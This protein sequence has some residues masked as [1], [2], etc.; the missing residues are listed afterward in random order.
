MPRKYLNDRSLSVPMLHRKLR[1][2]RDAHDVGRSPNFQKVDDDDVNLCCIY[3]HDVLLF[4]EPLHCPPTWTSFPELQTCMRLYS[5]PKAWTD[6]SLICK[7]AGGDLVKIINT[8]EE[9]YVNSECHSCLSG[10]LCLSHCSLTFFF[11]FSSS[12]SSAVVIAAAAAF[13]YLP[14]E[15]RPSTNS[16]QVLSFAISSSSLHVLPISS[17]YYSPLSL[18]LF[19]VCL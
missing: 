13:C 14:L 9:I 3:L 4:P 11:F 10:Y 2:S 16:C 18:I 5:T 6:A 12:S 17:P 15:H 8:H 19:S 7:Q 1:Q